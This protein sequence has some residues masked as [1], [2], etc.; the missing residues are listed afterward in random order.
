[1]SRHFS[2]RVSP[3][4]SE[5]ESVTGDKNVKAKA[6]PSQ[7]KPIALLIFLGLLGVGAAVYSEELKHAYGAA[8]RSGRVVGTLAVCI[9]E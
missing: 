2:T 1:M 3:L 6:S 9:N 7:K 4:R 5:Q 8:R